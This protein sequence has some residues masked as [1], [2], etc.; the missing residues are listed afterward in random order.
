MA[1]EQTGCEIC[2]AEVKEPEV[3][4][5]RLRRHKVEVPSVGGTSMLF[6]VEQN[7]DGTRKVSLVTGKVVEYQQIVD[8]QFSFVIV[9]TTPHEMALE[10]SKIAKDCQGHPFDLILHCSCCVRRIE[11]FI[12][13]VVLRYARPYAPMTVQRTKVWMEDMVRT[14]LREHVVEQLERYSFED[15]R[16]RDVLTS[17]WW[18]KKVR[19]WLD[20]SG[21]DIRI[22]RARWENPDADRERIEELNRAAM[23]RKLK[24]EKEL[25]ELQLALRDLEKE[26]EERRREE[27][28]QKRKR[29]HDDEVER[30]LGEIEIQDLQRRLRQTQTR[31]DADDLAVEADRALVN[32][33]EGQA[34]EIDQTRQ[35]VLSKGDQAQKQ[36]E[37]DF[38]D[39]LAH[40][41]DASPDTL[42]I[43]TDAARDTR[44]S[45]RD[46]GAPE[47]VTPPR[48]SAT[49]QAKP[50]PS[51]EVEPLEGETAEAQ[52]Q[53]QAEARAERVRQ[54]TKKL[55]D[56]Y[57]SVAEEEHVSGA[58]SEGGG[59]SA[60][61]YERIAR[62]FRGVASGNTGRR[63]GTRAA[64]EAPEGDT[65]VEPPVPP[66]QAQA[67]SVVADLA[68]TLENL[69]P[70]SAKARPDRH[71][72]RPAPADTSGESAEP[73]PAAAEVTDQ[74]GGGP[75][76][77]IHTTLAEKYGVQPPKARS[78]VGPDATFRPEDFVKKAEPPSE[79][80]P[81]N[82]SDDS[83]D[84][85]EQADSCSQETGDE[86]RD[87]P[88]G[89]LGAFAAKMRAAE[90]AA[91]QAPKARKK[92]TTTPKKFTLEP[93][94][95][96]G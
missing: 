48:P 14:R 81:G 82:T 5:S 30:M 17:S 83:P 1:D 21:V 91:G 7:L 80:S 72:A 13:K 20:G 31:S 90:K 58:A 79:D 49:G 3:I 78:P 55:G 11:E 6:C 60:F 29:D 57:G 23:R 22:D 89:L 15:L 44:P 45:D 73:A 66:V 67:K 92:P 32:Q 9:H 19:S 18:E 68:N 71:T 2:L 69:Y 62:A 46:T 74:A 63:G 4:R 77:P 39:E 34:R 42:R 16:D 75:D 33:D 95:K 8:G 94:K 87:G 10:F 84:G 47:S 86:P 12:D 25:R 24:D 27:E 37:K 41:L 43:I 85:S 53:S 54:L 26:E 76:K 61:D 65:P 50:S 93:K 56:L 38:A 52:A 70:P 36:A 40:R 35:D 28:K 59:G 51:P 88:K 64:A 96:D